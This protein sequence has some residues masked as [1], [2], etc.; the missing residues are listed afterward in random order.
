MISRSNATP[1]HDDVLSFM[2]QE[3][4]TNRLHAIEDIPES[5]AFADRSYQ[6]GIDAE[7]QAESAYRR[8]WRSGIREVT[9]QRW[10]R[11]E[12]DH[13]ARYDVEMKAYRQTMAALR[14]HALEESLFD[15]TLPP[16]SRLEAGI[17]CLVSLGCYPA[18]RWVDLAGLRIV[19]GELQT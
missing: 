9:R 13:R 16:R 15:K 19:Q 11:I 3:Y 12:E 8:Q 7:R 14:R 17:R 1:S 2:R 4:G 6:R 18:P 10:E 5:R